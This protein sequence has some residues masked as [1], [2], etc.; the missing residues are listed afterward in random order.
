VWEYLARK[1]DPDA[2]GAIAPAEYG[3][4][5]ADFARLD[6]DRDGVLTAADFDG[7]DERDLSIRDIPPEMRAF[8]GA[9]YAARAVVMTYFQPDPARAGSELSREA[10]EQGFVRLDR[11]GSGALDAT[12]FAR[13]TD[14]LPWGGPGEAWELLLAAIDAPADPR[15]ASGGESARPDGL[16]AREELV[17]YHAELGGP[18]RVL[19]PPPGARPRDPGA[20]V[21]SDGPPVGSLA[22]DFALA[23]PDGGARVRLSDWRGKQPVALIFG[24]FT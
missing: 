16:V 4:A 20:A 6:L 18:E 3:R 13:A 21:A 7:L 8:L 19:R 11:D 15:R 14:A 10:L 22:P 1:Y 23:P 12:E 17:Q 9:R 24:S 5:E 2:D